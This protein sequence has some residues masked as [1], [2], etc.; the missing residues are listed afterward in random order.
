MTAALVHHTP[1]ATV[2]EY[3]QG[4]ALTAARLSS[5]R[6]PC[7]MLLAEDDP[8]VPIEQLADLKVPARLCVRRTRYGGHC[9]F[10]ESPRALTLAERFVL[11]QFASFG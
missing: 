11:E 3:L 5:V 8:L 6:V 4:Y 7:G 2:E 10:I 9:G 1:F